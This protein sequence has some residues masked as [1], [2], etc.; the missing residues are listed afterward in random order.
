MSIRFTVFELY[1]KPRDL[2]GSSLFAPLADSKLDAMA[3]SILSLSRTPG[4]GQ[5]R[6]T[7]R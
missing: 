2:A 5:A 6:F 7:R 1:A 3:A 4:L